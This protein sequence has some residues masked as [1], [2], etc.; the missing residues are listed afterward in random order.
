MTTPSPGPALFENWRAALQNRDIIWAY[1]CPLYSDAWFVGETITV[2][3]YQLINTLAHAS[4]NRA[5][6]QVAPTLVLRVNLH[7]ER[8]KPKMDKTDTSRYHGGWLSDEV[9]ALAALAMGARVEAGPTSREF[10]PG[11][12]VRGKPI[13]HF[14]F[15]IPVLSQNKLGT[16]LPWVMGRHSAEDLSWIAPAF[17]TDT[18]NEAAL[19]RAA[20]L[21]QDAI[22]IADSEP[23]LSWL[24]LVSALE[25]AADRWRQSRRATQKFVDFILNFLPPPPEKRP[26]EA[27][28]VAWSPEFLKPSL[29]KIYDHRSKALHTGVPFPA[30]MCEPQIGDREWPAP[31]ER[32]ACLAA[33][34][35]GGVWLR[36]DMPI[37]LHIF[38]YIVRKVLQA[39][40]SSLRPVEAPPFI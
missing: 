13:A 24:L 11:A 36:E 7:V 40:W 12:D 4:S 39:W 28:R 32:P 5:G 10:E 6:G 16:I 18:R 38:E 17:D 37:S 21:Y 23:A 31:A 34:A 20:R 25:T 30:P 9:A 2:G 29:Q 3:P 1:E 19:I 8:E 33:S 22:W 35:H 15:G 26:E 27:Y 14:G